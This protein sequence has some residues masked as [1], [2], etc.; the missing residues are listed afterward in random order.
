MNDKFYFGYL[1]LILAQLMVGICIVTQKA[2]LASFPITTILFIRFTSGF[3]FLLLL[4]KVFFGGF[5][6]PLKQ[7]KRIDWL[8]IFFQAVFAGALFNILLL[9]GMHYT[10]ASIAAIITSALPAIVAIF[11]I[12]F[13]KEKIT[14]FTILCILFTIGGLVIINLH[15]LFNTNNNSLLGDFIV[16]L[17]LL[18]EAGYYILSKIHEN[19]LPVF[20]VS[21]LMNGINIPLFLLFL[22]IPSQHLGGYFSFK[23]VLLFLVVGIS[24]ALFYV[25]WYLGYKR[26]SGSSA[27]LT[28]AF[29]P[30]ATLL[31]AFIFLGETIS[32][33][34][35]VGMIFV[36]LSIFVNARR[37]P[38]IIRP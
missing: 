24:S 28:T 10:S 12:I 14:F 8:F 22:F 23:I 35:L 16:L 17:S 5:F 7:L 38:K 29:M 15:N 3:V 31:V 32:L 9:L 30:I 26:V 2:L 18:P 21:A 1:L 27:G 19:K 13:L 36:I 33:L 20:L 34:Q 6:A 25:F 11:S 4:H 37:K